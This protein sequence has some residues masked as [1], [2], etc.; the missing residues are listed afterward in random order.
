MNSKAVRS[1]I[2]SIIVLAA[3]YLCSGAA[4]ASSTYT[5]SIVALGNGY[6]V[7]EVVDTE[8]ST[9]SAYANRSLSGGGICSA[10]P[11]GNIYR[12]NG[13]LLDYGNYSDTNTN[14]YND[15]IGFYI[16]FDPANPNTLTVWRNLIATT[17]PLD[18]AN[19]RSFGYGGVT[20]TS[21]LLAFR[22]DGYSGGIA[23]NALGT[24]PVDQESTTTFGT[25]YSGN[26][27]TLLAG[28][29]SA[30]ETWSVGNI[31]EHQNLM[32]SENWA[33]YLGMARAN[34]PDGGGFL[35]PHGQYL[36]P[37]NNDHRGSPTVN[38]TANV[39]ACVSAALPTDPTPESDEWFRLRVIN[40]KD[41]GSSTGFS[42]TS[43]NTYSFRNLP[44]GKRYAYTNFY[45]RS[46]YGGPEQISINDH[47]DIA[48]PVVINVHDYDYLGS[49]V[50][51]RTC[52]RLGV[53]FM[54]HLT[55]G[56]FKCAV[57]NLNSTTML[58]DPSG[59]YLSCI[60]GVAIDNDC[61]IYFSTNAWAGVWGDTIERTAAI[62]KA[63]ANDSSNPS[64]WTV[65]PILWRGASWNDGTNICSITS[66][67]IG[68]STAQDYANNAAFCTQDINRTQLPGKTD[69]RYDV[70]GLFVGAYVDVTP[71]TG[72]TTTTNY[73][74]G[75][76]IAPTDQ[77]AP[78]QNIND[79]KALADNQPINLMY[80]HGR[81]HRWDIH[82][83]NHRQRILQIRGGSRKRRADS[84]VDNK[85]RPAGG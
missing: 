15:M 64:G 51:F 50:P 70:G 36:T 49:A 78:A 23:G 72:T 62:Y 60:A 54:S 30:S 84:N 76:Y 7:A 56:V 21:G 83:P 4:L 59:N 22:M 45:S 26:N 2:A 35:S 33:M 58:Y 19:I 44:D 6:G 82:R 73:A 61:N 8:L 74:R 40:Y 41:D 66:L 80:L 3:A 65:E 25:A 42:T 63:S 14:E 20:Q 79:A 1:I 27:F 57:D 18:T 24:L 55:P 71:S 28:G 53:L 34:F 10:F 52:P 11:S 38:D 9:V 5:R 13:S 39:I 75:L 68:N 67:P 37:P 77:T 43:N 48:F 46:S 31:G 47:G 85:I 32:V 29:L 81:V 16:T 69:P 12:V 17:I